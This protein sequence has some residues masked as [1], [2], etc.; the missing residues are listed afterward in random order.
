MV[1]AAEYLERQRDIRTLAISC[2]QHQPLDEISSDTLYLLPADEKSVVMTRSFSSMLLGA[3]A[4]A[5]QVANRQEI[6]E[7]H[8]A[9]F[10]IVCR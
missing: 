9:G 5:A 10:P 4:L 1:R 7:G 2:A 8:S 3:Q 6:A